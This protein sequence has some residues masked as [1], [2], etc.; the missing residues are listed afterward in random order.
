MH[1]GYGVA[2]LHP[3]AFETMN[4]Q[5]TGIAKAPDPEKA[6]EAILK[7]LE[8]IK[9]LNYRHSTFRKWKEVVGKAL[10]MFAG[11]EHPRTGEFRKLEFSGPFP[12]SPME[13][14]VTDKDVLM[15]ALGVDKTR[16]ILEA[17][18]EEVRERRQAEAEAEG[19]RKAESGGFR[20]SKVAVPRSQ[21]PP[22]GTRI[23]PQAGTE[24]PRHSSVPA[25]GLK[26]VARAGGAIPTTIEAYI[27]TLADEEER[28]LTVMLAQVL[29]N[30]D[31]K[32]A[33][34]R[35]VLAEIWWHR[36]DSLQKVIPIIL[37]R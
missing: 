22:A 31:A 36:R 7:D 35:D 16:E 14:A 26:I 3:G 21:V 10:D 17:V 34:V 29:Q 33:E 28:A 4:E 1:G 18:R 9:T 24:L 5:K 23:E 12:R 30:P 19:A 32:W 27:N 6:L 20:L 15:Y 8:M 37:K 25:D 13:P 11:A 2:R